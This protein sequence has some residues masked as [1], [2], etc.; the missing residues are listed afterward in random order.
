M[1]EY[2]NML[3][4]LC[5]IMQKLNEEGFVHNDLK[6][7][8]VLCDLKAGRMEVTLIDLGNMSSVDSRPYKRRR[9]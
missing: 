7:D 6:G 9:I 3:V 4:Q 2:L 8:N 1:K 5:D